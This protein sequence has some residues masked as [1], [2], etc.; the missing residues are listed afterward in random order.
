MFPLWFICYL[1]IPSHH[2]FLPSSVPAP[3][4]LDWVS[5]IITLVP[6]SQPPSHNFVQW[7]FLNLLWRIELQMKSSIKTYIR[8]ILLKNA[9]RKA[10]YTYLIIDI[11][12]FKENAKI[13]EKCSLILLEPSLKQ[14]LA[15]KVSIIYVGKSTNNRKYQHHIKAKLWPVVYVPADTHLPALQTWTKNNPGG[16]EECARKDSTGWMLIICD[17]DACIFGNLENMQMYFISYISDFAFTHHP[18]FF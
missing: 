14:F 3:A 12:I 4:H 13:I 6:A 5:L 9:P 8:Q 17:M 7:M 16:A 10:S 18:F 15:F 2:G 11:E 1:F